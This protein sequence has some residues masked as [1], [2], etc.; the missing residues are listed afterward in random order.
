MDMLFLYFLMTVMII[1]LSPGPAMM[2]VLQQSQ[3]SGIRTGT[4]AALGVELGVFIYVILTAFGVSAIF[5]R[6]PTVY[7]GIQLAGAAYLLYLAYL[8]WPRGGDVEDAPQTSGRGAFIKGMFINLTNPK[9]VL[10]FLSL[11]PQF[12]PSGANVETFILYGII[13]NIGGAIVNVSVALLSGY[14]AGLLQN[15]RWFDYVPPILFVAIALF[16]I[17]ERFA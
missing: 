3:R 1:N 6:F 4:S 14:A 17:S 2:F 7:T 10:F 12:V 15:S 8:S 9:I 5:A 11:I 16:S 13:F